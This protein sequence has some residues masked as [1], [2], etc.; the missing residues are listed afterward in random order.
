[1]RH[2]WRTGLMGAAA[3]IAWLSITGT[4]G[5]VEYRLRVV[6]IPDTAYASFLLPGELNNGA[7]GPGLNRL[8]AALDRGQFPKGTV[9]FD[10]RVQPVRE[11]LTRA[12]G[13]ARV[14]PEAIWGGVAANGL[15]WD[16]MIWEGKPG[17]HSVWLLSPSIINYF[18]EVYN[19]AL[20]GGGP[21]RNYQPFTYPMDRTRVTA[22]SMPLNFLW[23]QEERGTVW[24][25]YV[26]RGLDLGQGIGL[27]IGANFNPQFPD[28]AY[29]IAR[30][31]E[32]PTT[33]KAV[34][35]W[36]QRVFD[37]QAPGQGFIIIH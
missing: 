31:A 8:E 16:E 5:A 24:E 30:H 27:V 4:A 29:I 11:S 9:L 32:Q 10:R 12:Y 26:S 37:R 36:R 23:V 6:S 25:K 19:V 34:V 2:V 15:V 20:R 21:L 14:I 7:S 18:Q 1:M 28:V 17:E 3:L 35:V 13:G 33:Y 22:L